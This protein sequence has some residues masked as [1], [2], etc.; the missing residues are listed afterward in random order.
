MT[1]AS[2]A[3][4][5]AYG[6]AL[7]EF[8]CYV[9]DPVAT[10]AKAVDDSPEFAMGH[11]LTGHLLLSGTDKV[12]L[13]DARAALARAAPLPMNGRERAHAAALSAFLV[14]EFAGGHE[15]LGRLA[16]RC[17]RDLAAV[18]LAHLWDFFLGDAQRLRERIAM[19]LPHWS[20]VDRDYHALLGMHAFGLEECG[21]Y[22]RAEDLGREAV[23]RNRRDSWAQHAVAHVLEMEGRCDEGVR[24]MRDNEDGWATDN[25]F[26]VHNY[27]HLALYHLDRGELSDVFEL[28]DGAIRRERSTLMLDMVDAA[29]LL[30]RL[31]LRG[32]DVGVRGVQLA[33]DWAPFAEDGF[34][35]FNDVHAAMAFVAT[36]RDVDLRRLIAAMVT[37]AKGE[38]TNAVLTREIGLPVVQALRAFG[39]GDYA[40]VVERLE[41]IRPIAHRFGGSHAQRDVLDLTLL[42]AALRGGDA[43]T[44]RA[45]AMER[46]DRKPASPLAERFAER[47]HSLGA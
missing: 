21:F 44:A 35:A 36:G 8:A 3:A 10:L 17:P 9:G 16:I 37:R 20:P 25:F 39:A 13:P 14:G 32:D 47:A 24:W 40:A 26:A 15:A 34:Y 33:D 28:Y 1:G 2:A 29:S 18:Q 42:E 30:W 41:P 46:A 5:E 6:Q 38:D 23:A 31:F 12:S 19:V 45:F 4:G 22:R 7:Q 43:A 27:W 11:L